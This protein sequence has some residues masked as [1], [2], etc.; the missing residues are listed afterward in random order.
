MPFDYDSDQGWPAEK[1]CDGSMSNTPR[2]SELAGPN[3]PVLIVQLAKVVIALNAHF[4]LAFFPF[5]LA[6]LGI[7]RPQWLI[8]MY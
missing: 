7:G 5:R 1:G 3:F 6:K 8:G 4:L 2:P